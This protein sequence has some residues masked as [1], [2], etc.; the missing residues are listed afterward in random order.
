MYYFVLIF[1]GLA[2][3]SFVNA[4]VWRIHESSEESSG[5][6]VLRGRSLCMHCRHVLAPRDLIPV[7]SYVQLKGK[8][9][10]CGAAIPDTPFAEV[11]LPLLFLASY[12]FWPHGFS[13]IGVT[14]FILW[15]SA[16]V[17]LVALLIYD[18]KWMILPDRL[19]AALALIA[20]VMLFLFGY[21]FGFWN[22]LAS[23]ALAAASI[24][25]LFHVLHLVSQGQWIGGGDVKLGYAIGLLIIQPLQALMV[26]FLASL[27][28]VVFA[29]PQL[30]RSRV[31]M[32]S[33]IPFGPFLIAATIAIFLFGELFNDWFA[34]AL[35]IA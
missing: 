9:R 15:L 29:L 34:Q 3:G 4:L 6:S 33:K 20:S 22:I 2:F 27:L 17:I 12:M 32:M 13:G 18:M 11:V 14:L 8:C 35:L 5:I 30:V 19:V 1:V 25:G 23:A 31:G 24:G 10:Y 16:L 26:I 21:D 28:G 7:I